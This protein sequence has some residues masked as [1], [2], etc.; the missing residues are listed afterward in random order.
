MDVT[1]HR[2]SPWRS[3]RAPLAR[4]GDRIEAAVLTLALAG[5]F[6]AIGAG[7]WAGEA[8]ADALAARGSGVGAGDYAAAGSGVPMDGPG[9]A[10]L[11]MSAAPF[12]VGVVTVLVAWLM[13]ASLWLATEAVWARRHASALDAEWA[14]VEPRW[15]GRS[16]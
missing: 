2:R 5:G 8:M 14:R 3:S 15:S 11:P 16:E 4:R 1:H 7:V 6:A 10:A 9:L 12:A 13:L